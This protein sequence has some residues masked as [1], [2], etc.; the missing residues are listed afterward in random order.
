MGYKFKSDD[1]DNGG[2]LIFKNKQI[3][4]AVDVGSSPNSDYSRDYQ[5][6]ALSFEII[7]RGQKLIS[8]CGYYKKKDERLNLLSKSSAT[9]STLIIDDNSSCKFYKSE[10]NWL[11]KRGLKI[12]EK[13][14]HL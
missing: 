7:S 2:Y 6:G 3:C 8:N 5:A 11:I 4:L 10:K 9:Q 14:L 13:K 1:Q 12:L